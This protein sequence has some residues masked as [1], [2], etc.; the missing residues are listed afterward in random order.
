MIVGAVR[1]V[2]RGLWRDAGR[3]P[4]A[5]DVLVD[6]RLLS[7]ARVADVLTAVAEG[8]EASGYG[9]LVFEVSSPLAGSIIS[10]H[11]LVGGDVL[12]PGRLV[13]AAV[14]GR[15]RPRRRAAGAVAMRDMGPLE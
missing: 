15:P 11:W 9:S 4:A 14:Y 12:E 13:E 3:R 5:G 2:V 1:L 7:A 10:R 6:V 8:L